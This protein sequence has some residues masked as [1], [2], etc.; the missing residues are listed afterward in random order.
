LPFIEQF[1]V[2][3]WLNI[4]HMRNPRTFL[5]LLGFIALLGVLALTL[6]K[7]REPSYGGH[8]LSYWLKNS[9]SAEAKPAIRSAGT[10]AIPWLLAWIRYEPHPVPQFVVNR[11]EWSYWTTPIGH[12]V[13]F[14][15]GSANDRAE[16]VPWAF[17]VLGT[18]GVPALGDLTTLMKDRAHPWASTRATMALGSIGPPALPA[19]AE[20]LFSTNQRERQLVALEL[21][22]MSHDPAVGTNKVLPFVV[23]AMRDPDQQVSNYAAKVFSK[24]APKASTKAPEQ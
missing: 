16:K 3:P 1:L 14:G 22:E 8:P 12:F 21:F 11:V 24:L 19:L 15:F 23:R 2:Y 7:T 4:G 17:G 18:N 6:R 9:K 13:M 5:F 20:A 10:N